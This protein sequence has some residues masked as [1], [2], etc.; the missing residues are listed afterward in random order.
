MKSLQ[1]FEVCIQVN[2]VSENFLGIL[3]AATLLSDRGSS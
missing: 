1:D 2:E 3:W